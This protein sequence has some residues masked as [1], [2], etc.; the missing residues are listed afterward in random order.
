VSNLADRLTNLV[1]G[2]KY[3]TLHA[4]IVIVIVLVLLTDDLA[5]PSAP[6]ISGYEAGQ[7]LNVGDE[8]ALECTAPVPGGALSWYRSGGA[9]VDER[10]LRSTCKTTTT[11]TTTAVGEVTTV[12]RLTLVVRRDHN[13]AVY[14]CSASYNVTSVAMTSSIQLTVLCEYSGVWTVT[15]GRAVK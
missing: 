8:V 10:P 3:N 6:T 2:S 9:S 1:G 14:T 7:R 13:S 15:H 4:A 12:C 5:P 11:T